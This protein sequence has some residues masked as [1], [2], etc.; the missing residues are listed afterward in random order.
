M[1]RRRRERLGLSM[2]ET[3]RRIG[4]SPS[5]LLALEHGRNPTTGRAPMPSPPILASIGQV[6]GI[7]LGTLLDVAGAPSSRSAHLLLYQTGPERLSALDGARRAFAGRVDAWIEV[8]GPRAHAADRTLG[9]ILAERG[10][11]GQGRRVGLIFGAG[12]NPLRSA[13]SPVALLESE[14][15]WEDDV[16]AAC[17]AALGA[18]PAANVCV[19]R[20]ADVRELTR[21]DP[22]A[23]ALRL[24][25]THPH[26][27]VQ[28]EAGV[29]TTG[30]AAVEA[31]LAGVRPAGIGPDT[32][33]TL[34]AAAGA[35]FGRAAL[36]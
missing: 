21:V 15:T 14:T 2:R 35:G 12:S 5:Y 16:A 28:D 33:A 13:E 10:G 25:Q 20:Q 29:V 23:A 4:I 30:P 26:V 22:L 17:Q 19:Y 6:L 7:E 36:G 31:I 1:L 8:A 18:R 3:A 9:G 34:A 24:V 27:A 32:W 11:W